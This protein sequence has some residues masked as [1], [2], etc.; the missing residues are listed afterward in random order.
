MY[1]I[2]KYKNIIIGYISKNNLVIKIQNL[3]G[4]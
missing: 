3:L 4:K 1:K 2:Y